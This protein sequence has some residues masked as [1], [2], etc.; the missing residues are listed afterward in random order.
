MA[1][2]EYSDQKFR[3]LA[4][5]LTFLILA[6]V[7][8]AVAWLVLRP[9]KPH[10]VLQNVVVFD[11]NLTAGDSVT[12]NF[13]VTVASRNPNGRIAVNYDR[14]VAGAAYRGQQITLPTRLPATYQAGKETIV[15]SPFLYGPQ[16]PVAPYVGVSLRQDQ[17]AGT[18]LVTVRVGGG[19][20]WKVGTVVSWKYRLT[21]NC[22]VYLNFPA[23]KNGS[24][25]AVGTA[26][27]QNHLIL[28]C[29]VDV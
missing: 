3:L 26:T 27:F 2:G 22:P 19:I 4:A 13:Q 8:V 15:W 28:D 18:V 25:V 14:L 5:L 12:A 29:H 24:G 21:V 16:I 20:R 23:R 1:A 17:I 6:G 11:L 7:T 10:F 9:S